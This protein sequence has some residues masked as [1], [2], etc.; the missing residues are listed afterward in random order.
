M[1]SSYSVLEM[2]GEVKRA[3]RGNL[4]R[5]QLNHYFAETP[6]DKRKVKKKR[7][8]IQP[9]ATITLKAVPAAM[10]A[11]HSYAWWKTKINQWEWTSDTKKTQHAATVGHDCAIS[12]GE[13]R[14][15]KADVRPTFKSSHSKP[16]KQ[17]LPRTIRHVAGAIKPPSAA[18]IP[19]QNAMSRWLCFTFLSSHSYI[20]ATLLFQIAWGESTCTEEC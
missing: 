1:I 6:G 14:V 17:R 3:E 16:S 15:K 7:R 5:G 19:F 20:L 10:R 9:E 12:G 8:K 11:W 18:H 13:E 2:I 4:G